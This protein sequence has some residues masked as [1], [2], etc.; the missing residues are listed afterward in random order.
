M[1]DLSPPTAPS[2]SYKFLFMCKLD[3]STNDF[4]GTEDLLLQAYEDTVH[5]GVVA[6]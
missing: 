1:N 5:V 4:F 3:E 6:A 2:F